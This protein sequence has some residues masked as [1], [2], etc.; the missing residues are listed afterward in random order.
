MT[1][2]TRVGMALPLLVHACLLLPPRRV[3]CDAPLSCP[4]PSVVETRIAELTATS[5]VE[6]IAVEATVRERG[7]TF[8]V[9]IVVEVDERRFARE[10]EAQ[11]CEALAEAVALVV[12]T[13]ADP[14]ASA[15]AL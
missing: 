8:V 7:G 2:E 1:A 14:L 12:A 4:S 3:I 5:D 13:T 15:A 10:L 6:D 9:S 11:R